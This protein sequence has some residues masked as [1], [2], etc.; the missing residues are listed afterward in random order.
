MKFQLLMKRLK[1]DLKKD[2]FFLVTTRRNSRDF[3]QMGRY[4]VV[5][6]NKLLVEA[7]VNLCEL[8]VRRELIRSHEHVDLP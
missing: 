7:D 6:N 3:W 4:A 2:G 1:R 5:N 8:A